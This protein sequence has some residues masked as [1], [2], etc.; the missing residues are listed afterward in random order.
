MTPG[1]LDLLRSLLT[2][3][4]NAAS[5]G[6]NALFRALRPRSGALY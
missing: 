5:G 3:D 6:V 4:T 1:F 2:S